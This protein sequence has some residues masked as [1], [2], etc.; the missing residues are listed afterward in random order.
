MRLRV[1]TPV[2]PPPSFKKSPTTK[3]LPSGCTAS[4]L[5]SLFAPGSKLMSIVPSEFRRPIWL[6]GKWPVP[7]PPR[8]VNSPPTTILPSACTTILKIVL[9]SEWV[10]RPLAPGS[11]LMSTVPSGF[12]RAMQLRETVPEPPPPQVVKFPP[13]K[14]LPSGC[15][16][17]AE[18]LSFAPGL[19]AMSSVPSGFSRAMRLR[20]NV[21]VPPPPRVVKLPPTNIFP[22]ACSARQVI[23]ALA[24]GLKLVSRVPSGFTRP[25]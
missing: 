20:T 1:K 16:A 12:S 2:P 8:R 22:S 17:I 25:I 4:P 13:T 10:P 14:I 15:S 6:R 3:I 9:S 24:P 18:I 5:T 21:P 7:P 19:K 23:S 11:K